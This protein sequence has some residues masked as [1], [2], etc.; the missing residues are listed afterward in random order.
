MVPDISSVARAASTSR[1]SRTT[2]RADEQ[3]RE[4]IACPIDTRQ[5]GSSRRRSGWE[6]EVV[7]GV[8][9]EASRCAAAAPLGEFCEGPADQVG[10]VPMPGRTAQVQLDAIALPTTPS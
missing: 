8:D 9:A 6:V 4:T 5:K 10:P 7:D 3:G 2:C 1:Y